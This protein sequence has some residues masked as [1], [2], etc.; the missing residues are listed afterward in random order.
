[1]GRG[2]GFKAEVSLQAAG[3]ERSTEVDQAAA[4]GIDEPGITARQAVI[5]VAGIEPVVTRGTEYS[6]GEGAA[7]ERAMSHDTDIT[8]GGE[9]GGQRALH[10]GDVL[11]AGEL[12][13]PEGLL[14]V[15]GPQGTGIGN[16][17]EA[18]I[19]VLEGGPF[20]LVRTTRIATGEVILGLPLEVVDLA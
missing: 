3:A 7:L 11:A 2:T 8:R 16:T 18:H 17:A 4:L 13:K 5:P 9:S 20:T 15:T 10:E 1:M 19:D 14:E 12:F 6:V